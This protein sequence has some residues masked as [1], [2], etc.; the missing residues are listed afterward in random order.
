VLSTGTVA[1]PCATPTDAFEGKFTTVVVCDDVVQWRSGTR[2]WVPVPVPGVRS[3]ADNGDAY[4]VAQVGVTGCK[5]VQIASLPAV[6]VSTTTK[7]TLVGCATDAGQ[8]G[9]IVVARNGQSVWLWSGDDVL[10]SASGG[11]SW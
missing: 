4:L 8:E 2:A 5:G 3:I 6:R 11:A 9:S 10:T 7:T 1:A